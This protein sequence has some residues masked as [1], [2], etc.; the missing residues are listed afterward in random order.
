MGSVPEEQHCVIAELV[1]RVAF[2]AVP[3]SSQCLELLLRSPLCCHI[4]S[5]GSFF[6]TLSSSVLAHRSTSPCLS[7]VISVLSLFCCSIPSDARCVRGGERLLSCPQGLA[8][9]NS[10]PLGIARPAKSRVVPRSTLCILLRMVSTAL[11]RRAV[12]VLQLKHENQ[13]VYPQGVLWIEEFAFQELHCR[14]RTE[15]NAVAALGSSL[16]VIPS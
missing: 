15:G 7:L 12:P 6:F 5:A 16:A 1:Q 9:V 3:D 8:L 13:M 2:L 4:S 11:E 14:G 10:V